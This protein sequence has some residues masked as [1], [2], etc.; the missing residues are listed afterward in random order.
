MKASNTKVRIDGKFG[1][2]LG[3]T[4][5]D[6]FKFIDCDGYVYNLTLKELDRV[7]ILFPPFEPSA[8]DRTKHMDLLSGKFNGKLCQIDEGLRTLLGLPL[9]KLSNQ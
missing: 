9:H 6:Y 3:V 8:A 5:D 7:E 4:A 2:F 1:E